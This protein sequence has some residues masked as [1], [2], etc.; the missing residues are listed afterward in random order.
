MQRLGHGKQAHGHQHNLHAVQ[1]LGHAAGVASLPG[2]L[3]HANQ[4]QC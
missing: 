1:Q 2:D 4:T 3:I